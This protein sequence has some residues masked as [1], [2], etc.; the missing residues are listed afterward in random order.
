M[1]RE[2]TEDGDYGF[3]GVTENWEVPLAVTQFILLMG[4]V[5][6]LNMVVLA[7]QSCIF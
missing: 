5:M 6:M 1:C 4:M 7:L 2:C 3:Q